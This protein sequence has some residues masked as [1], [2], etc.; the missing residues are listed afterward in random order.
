[1]RARWVAWVGL[2][3]LA[4]RY[5]CNLTQEV[6]VPSALRNSAG[7][8]RFC[9]YR[10]MCSAWV[11]ESVLGSLTREIVP[12]LLARPWPYQASLPPLYPVTTVTSR[13]R[14]ARV[15]IVTPAASA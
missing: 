13:G 15:S 10:G 14:C 4:M 8:Q 9:L 2:G 5:D 7:P 3:V 12:S 1:M 6:V 11:P